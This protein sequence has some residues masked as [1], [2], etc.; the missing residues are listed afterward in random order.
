MCSAKAKTDCTILKLSYEK[1]KKAR[2]DFESLDYIMSQYET[3]I[4]DRG[5]PYCDY[6]LYRYNSRKLS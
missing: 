6:K 4:E 2:K 5:P 3:Y 1:L